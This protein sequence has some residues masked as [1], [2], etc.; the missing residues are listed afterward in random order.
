MRIPGPSTILS[1]ASTLREEVTDLVLDIPATVGDVLALISRAGDMLDRVERLLVRAEG[2][3]DRGEALLDR[4]GDAIADAEGMLVASN[5]LL[6]RADVLVAGAERTAAA[7]AATVVDVDRTNEAAV[8]T[9]GAAA[10]TVVGV[11]DLLRRTDRLLAPWEPIAGKVAP[12]AAD[13]AHRLDDHEV[14]ALAGMVDKLPQLLR[15]LEEDVLPMLGKLDQVGPDVH[16]ILETVHEMT[17]AI[18]GFPGAG[19]L[20]RRGEKKEDEESD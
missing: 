18:S 7:A 5:T 13:F 12:L 15:S 1:A 11:E 6:L 19:F 14:A 3:L 4:G 8:S 9:V 10:A 17:L 16:E 2:L 20:K